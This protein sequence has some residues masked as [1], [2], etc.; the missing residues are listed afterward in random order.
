VR[1]FTGVI[2][3][4]LAG[5][6]AT[7]ATAGETVTYS[8]DAFGRLTQ[9]ATAGT[10]NNGLNAAI[11]YDAADNRST[12]TVTGSMNS[13]PVVGGTVVVLGAFIFTPIMAPL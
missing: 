9:S 6:R 2:I 1:K 5:L 4:F 3:L 12:Y 13:T 11:T 10:I 8:Y 7:P